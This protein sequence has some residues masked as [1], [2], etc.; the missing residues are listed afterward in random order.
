MTWTEPEVFYQRLA[1]FHA[2][3]A[4]LITESGT[5]RILLVKPTYKDSWAWPGGYLDAG[6]YPQDGCAR[7]LAEELG[8]TIAVGRLLLLDFAPPAG[9]RQRALFSMTFDCGDLPADATVQLQPD[10]LQA[11]KFFTA[12]EAAERLP[13]TERHRAAAALHARRH[14]TTHY[15]AAGRGSR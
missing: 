9:K 1:A 4:A 15:L 2:T 3:A 13:A 6:E 11:W 12:E 14:R 7:E 5:G 10:E 8:I